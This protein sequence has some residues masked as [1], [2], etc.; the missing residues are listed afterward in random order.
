MEIIDIPFHN[1]DISIR[2]DDHLGKMIYKFSV[3]MDRIDE[4]I[5]W[6]FENTL[7]RFVLLGTDRIYFES[8]ADAMAFKLGWHTK[9]DDGL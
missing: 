8:S 7:E 1:Q 3:D 6:L 4:M 9:W 2:A 5:E